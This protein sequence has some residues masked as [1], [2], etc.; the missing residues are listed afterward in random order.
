MLKDFP[1]WTDAVDCP[2]LGDGDGDCSLSIVPPTNPTHRL[3]VVTRGDSVEV[4]YH[5]GEPPGPVEALFVDLD[6]HPLEVAE[7]IVGFVHD[8]I[9]GRVVVVRTRFFGPR[10]Q[11]LEQL[12]KSRASRDSAVYTWKA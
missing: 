8:I 9:D 7:S 11:T 10:F 12:N 2:G 3:D 5:Y 6:R 1:E 4:R